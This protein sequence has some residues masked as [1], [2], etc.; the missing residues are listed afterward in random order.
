M[1]PCAYVGVECTR[2]MLGQN[3][4]GPEEVSHEGAST[5][6]LTQWNP[7]SLW[8]QRH[9]QQQQLT[10]VVVINYAA[11]FVCGWVVIPLNSR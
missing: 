10:D 1:L 9:H 4:G 5:P 3:R 2:G 11:C 7:F 6:N 8:L